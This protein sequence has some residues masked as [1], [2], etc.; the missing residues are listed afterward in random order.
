MSSLSSINYLTLSRLFRLF[1]FSL[2]NRPPLFP[3]YILFLTRLIVKK[4]RQQNFTVIYIH[5]PE[6]FTLF[7]F[8]RSSTHATKI[9]VNRLSLSRSV[10][11]AFFP[12]RD[13]QKRSKRSPKHVYIR[14]VTYARVRGR[15]KRDKSL[16]PRRD[17]RKFCIA[18]LSVPLFDMFIISAY[19]TIDRWRLKTCK[20]LLIL[21]LRLSLSVSDSLFRSV[22]YES[23]V[24]T[25]GSVHIYIYIYIYNA[26]SRFS[27]FLCL[28]FELVFFSTSSLYLSAL[29]YFF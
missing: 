29:F 8:M 2:L 12:L 19:V 20:L 22:I 5:S 21:C 7:T 18:T 27:T 6:F 3:F 14:I 4:L 16:H 24:H 1:K 28:L 9:I 11:S 26:E 23:Y 10:L 25:Y 15:T 17:T 13:A